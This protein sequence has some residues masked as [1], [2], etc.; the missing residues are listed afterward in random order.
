MKKMVKQRRAT[1]RRLIGPN[2]PISGCRSAARLVTAVDDNREIWCECCTCGV[3]P[4]LDNGLMQH[5]LL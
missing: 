4:E 5:Y 1:G 2:N 3:T